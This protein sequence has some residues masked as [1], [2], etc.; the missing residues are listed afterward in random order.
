MIDPPRLG[1]KAFRIPPMYSVFK[2]RTSFS[3][4]A[5]RIRS[6]FGG[7]ERLLRVPAFY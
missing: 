3:T 4:V 2:D 7:S 5:C 1:R 6:W